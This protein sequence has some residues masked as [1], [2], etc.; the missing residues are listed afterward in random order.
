MFVL[1]S[2][3]GI[4]VGVVHKNIDTS[5]MFDKFTCICFRNAVLY[6]HYD[7]STSA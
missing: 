2:V 6:F 1:I 7:M 4:I 3:I 5:V